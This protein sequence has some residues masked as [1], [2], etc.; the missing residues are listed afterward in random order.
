MKIASLILLDSDCISHHKFQ[1]FQGHLIFATHLLLGKDGKPHLLCPVNC[2]KLWLQMIASYTVPHLFFNVK[3]D[4]P[5]HSP[6]FSHLL[7]NL[8]HTSHL[9]THLP[10][11]LHGLEELR[12][13]TY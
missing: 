7:V 9:G 3:C 10:L 4:K 12:W 11:F 1:K 2:L 6:Q 8:I 13:K 5:L